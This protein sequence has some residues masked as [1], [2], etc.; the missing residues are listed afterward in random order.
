M[1]PDTKFL[2]NLTDREILDVMREEIEAGYANGRPAFQTP[3]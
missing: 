2:M 1:K 3:A